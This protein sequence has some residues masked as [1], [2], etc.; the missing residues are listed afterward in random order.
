M[1]SAQAPK[2]AM[3]EEARI[4]ARLEYAQARAAVQI[5]AVTRFHRVVSSEISERGR[6]SG[7]ASRCLLVSFWPTAFN[8]A[9]GFLCCRTGLAL[10]VQK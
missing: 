6:R 8:A 2:L 5:G 10:I 9:F 4:L 1:Q 7:W 3:L